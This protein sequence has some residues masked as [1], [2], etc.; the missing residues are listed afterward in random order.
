MKKRFLENGITVKETQ[1]SWY[2]TCP[3]CG[4]EDKA[5]LIKSS[6]YTSCWSCGRNWYNWAQVLKQIF[7]GDSE[8]V[9]E[10]VNEVQ[11]GD[12]LNHLPFIIHRTGDEE[13]EET[14]LVDFEPIELPIDFIPVEQ[15]ET[16]MAYLIERGINSAE[17]VAQFDIRYSS[18]MNAIVFPVKKGGLAY[19]W[20]ARRI[21]P[22]GNLPKVQTSKGFKKAEFLLNFNTI[23]D[24]TQYFDEILTARVK[25]LI[26]VE[27]PVDCI[28]ANVLPQ[29]VAVASFGKLVSRQQLD[30][31]IQSEA[32]NIYLGLDRDAGR[33][34][35]K[36]AEALHS[37]KRIFRMLP[38]EH[39]KDM[40]E[41]T[42]EE[43]Q[44]SFDGAV[45]I[46]AIRAQWMEVY[47]KE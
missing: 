31:L 18:N 21:R 34:L 8:E 43:I 14:T 32:E 3:G 26:L 6:G 38:P 44:E 39:R 37:H 7:K 30:L 5:W 29:A 13:I 16:G 23:Q 4:K 40:G 2:F 17:Q 19:G 45:E 42:P 1:R 9:L 47:L 35:M 27:G 25:N 36:L 41:C 15:S 46:S 33:E 24:R 28:H 12:V 20:Q 22:T 11:T 10:A